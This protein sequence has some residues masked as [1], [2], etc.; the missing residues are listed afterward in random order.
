MFVTSKGTVRKN[1]ISDFRKVRRNGKQV[2]KISKEE[3]I[4]DIFGINK[5][6]LIL[7]ASKNGNIILFNEE[8]I[9]C[10]ASTYS[11][12]VRAMKMKSN[13]IV[14]KAGIAK[15]GMM[16]LTITAMGFGKLTDLEEYRIIKRGGSGVKLCKL[17]KGD[18]IIGAYLCKGDEE[19]IM[20]T[21]NG[22]IFKTSCSEIRKMHKNT[23][24]VQICRVKD[25]DRVMFA[26]VIDEI[27]DV[28]NEI[29]LNDDMGMNDGIIQDEI[30]VTQE[31]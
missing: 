25:D 1:D 28:S 26:N 15:Q 4:I 8:D 2:M 24:G 23:K 17:Q 14:I 20:G 22:N 9:R 30:V 16:L 13:D 3:N 21:K 18:E 11:M 19:L 31:D 7:I 27:E 29:I 6:D 5:N 10:F 12:G